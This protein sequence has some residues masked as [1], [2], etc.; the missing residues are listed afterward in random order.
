MANVISMADFT[1][2]AP[3]GDGERLRESAERLAR[4]LLWH[5]ENTPP[6]AWAAAAK[7][8]ETART[9]WPFN[10][11]HS[12]YHARP[13]RQATPAESAE[14]KRLLEAMRG[15]NAPPADLLHQLATDPDWHLFDLAITVGGEPA[16]DVI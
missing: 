2:S 4:V 9:I 11:L 13:K 1:M 12:L 14:I 3:T 6:G 7:S 16:D 15:G 10:L 5:T 8:G